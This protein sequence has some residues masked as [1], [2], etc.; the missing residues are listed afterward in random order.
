MGAETP[1]SEGAA[2]P[3]GQPG[4]APGTLIHVGSRKVDETRL[5]LMHYTEERFEERE[6]DGVDQCPAAAEAA[7]VCWLNIDGLHDVGLIERIGKRFGLHH[8]TLEDILNTGQRPKLEAYEN[9]LYLVLKMVR[10]D[11]ESNALLVEQV[12][13]IFGPDFV[14]SFQEAPGDV[15]G[16]VRQ[17]VRTKDSRLRGHKAGFMAYA[18]MDAI[19]DAYFL[20]IERLNDAA[21]MLEDSVLEEPGR[22]TLQRIQRLRMANITLRK[23][24]MPLRD[25][26]GAMQRL[27]T[28]LLPARLGP[29][30][31][32]VYDHAVQT[33]DSVEALRDMISSLRD[34]YLS[35]VSNRMND[36]MKVL[37]IIATIFIP[38][39]F[40]AGVYGMNFK[41]MPELGWPYGYYAALGVM[42]AVA[43]TM[44]AYFWKK[45]WL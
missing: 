10:H 13:I 29:Y 31:A 30:L 27:T 44:L 4:L 12:S 45:E 34:T 36:I 28:P 24:V 26:I 32:D 11:E 3:A 37:T 7:G 15:F 41:E 9:Y 19:V 25:V 42:V 22:E 33:M 38:I 20:V 6:I 43:L 5:T 35:A 39:T 21:E 2:R 8:L 17:R 1:P 18:L 23:A 40:V 14:L 16:E